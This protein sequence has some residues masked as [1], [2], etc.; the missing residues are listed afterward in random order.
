MVKRN[1]V[2]RKLNK[3]FV[4]VWNFDKVGYNKSKL[5]IN[6]CNKFHKFVLTIKIF[7]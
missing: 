4:K 1:V 7:K 6:I 3:N 5:S 2:I